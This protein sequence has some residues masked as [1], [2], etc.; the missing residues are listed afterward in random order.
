MGPRGCGVR[1]KPHDPVRGTLE[2]VARRVGMCGDEV[3]TQET[4]KTLY[5][6]NLPGLG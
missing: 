1:A 6:G 2:L 3:E 5:G 4:A